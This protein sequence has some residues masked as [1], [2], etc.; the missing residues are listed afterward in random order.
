MKTFIKER[1]PVTIAILI[2]VGVAFFIGYGVG[3]ERL[4]AHSQPTFV[5]GGDSEETTQADF[6][7]FWRVWNILEK[8]F[9]ATHKKEVIPTD[10]EKVW[11]AIQGLTASYGDPYTV[12]FPPIQS[13]MFS[14]D[15]EGNFSGVGMEVGYRDNTLTVIAPLKDTP[16]DKAGIKAGDTL[17][18]IDG[19]STSDM[20]LE[21]VVK[22]IR[23]VKGTKVIFTVMREG[24]TKTEEITVVRDS[25]D[26]PTI[27]SILRP[28]GVFVISLYNFSA[29]SADLFRGALRQ[30]IISGSHKLVLDLR[31]NPGGFLDAAQDMASWFLPA[32]K[33]IVQEAYS[34][35]TAPEV[36]RSKGYN[37]FG[38]DLKMVI[39]VDDGSASAAEIL[40][41]ALKEQGVATLVG[42]KTFGK[43][44]VQEL[45]NITPETSL[46]VTVARWLTPEGHSFSD[47]GITPDVEVP[48]TKKDALAGRDPQLEKAV[49]ILNSK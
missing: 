27:N 38:K 11:G 39:L 47:I 23:G 43:G 32:G 19:V 44:S 31:G 18:Q 8:K 9:V 6:G 5:T 17:V 4:T 49:S 13:Q 1:L 25:I 48:Y 36:F 16:A 10:Q 3:I 30:F 26:I 41:G 46:K 24:E 22:R 21:D 7:P 28:D 15:I 20:T 29:I 40:A 33:I 2:L 34:D 12:F 37:V 42:Q 45:V 35:G 14:E